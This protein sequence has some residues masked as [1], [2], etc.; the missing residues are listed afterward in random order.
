[1]LVVVSEM[2]R[3]DPVFSQ[4]SGTLRKQSCMLRAI[5][6]EELQEKK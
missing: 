2:R 5:F 4:S 6:Y 3:A 1:M